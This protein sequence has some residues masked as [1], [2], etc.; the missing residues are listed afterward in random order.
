M[1]KIRL[2]ADLNIPEWLDRLHLVTDPA[3][4][5]EVLRGLGSPDAAD[6]RCLFV[7]VLDGEYHNVFAAYAFPPNVRTL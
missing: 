4:V 1:T 2:V 5:A 7:E 6:Y 3:D